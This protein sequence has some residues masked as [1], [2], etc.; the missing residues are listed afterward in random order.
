MSEVCAALFGYGFGYVWENEGVKD[1]GK[2]LDVFKQHLVDCHKQV[3][4]H[5]AVGLMCTRIL[6]WN[7]GGILFILCLQRGFKRCS[8]QISIR[9]L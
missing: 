7:A 1:V 5:R 8:N 2:F 4:L 9:N 6:S 3:M